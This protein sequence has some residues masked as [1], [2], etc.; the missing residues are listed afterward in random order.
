MER[1]NS[2]L[3]F[4][5]LCV[6]VLAGAQWASAQNGP[7]V[8]TQSL[9][10]NARVYAIVL[11]PTNPHIIYAA[12]L[13]SGVYKT[14]N[15]GVSWFAI[16]SGLTYNKVQAMAISPSEPEVLYAGTDQNGGS[17]SG[18]YVTTNAGGTWTLIDNGITDSKGIQAIVVSP[19]DPNT[20]MIGVFDGLVNSTIGLY[21]TT[22]AGGTWIASNTGFGANKNVLSLAINP[23]N[24]NTIYAGTSFN[25]VTSRGPSHIYKSANGGATWS[26]VNAGLPKDTLTIDPVRTLSIS[27]ADTSVV[28]AGLFVNDTAGG[29]FLTTDGGLTWTKKHTGLPTVTGTL[30]RS[31]L[32]RP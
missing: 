22:D 15:T 31:C 14:T 32:I 3:L 10:N 27:T 17:N 26:D 21:K 24:G 19:T 2:V 9:G 16:N 30:L 28:L 7:F 5:A 1:G 29:A 18:M 20:A 12:G 6:L 25:T 11:D 13:D 4:V 8:W 23:L